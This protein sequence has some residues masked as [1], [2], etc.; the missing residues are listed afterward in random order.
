M[1]TKE[2]LDAYFAESD[3]KAAEAKIA[4]TV[5]AKR[6]VAEA[7]ATKAYS[8]VIHK[9]DRA[10]S[11]SFTLSGWELSTRHAAVIK[12]GITYMTLCNKEIDCHSG[13][14]NEAAQSDGTEH[15]TC[16]ACRKKLGLKPLKK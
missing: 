14:G 2:Q 5:E 11:H 16:A 3:R 13:Y 6:K 4:K 9:G 10:V 15:I 12:D 8:H 1:L 7:I